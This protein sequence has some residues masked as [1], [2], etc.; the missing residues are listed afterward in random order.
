MPGG[1]GSLGAGTSGGPPLSFDGPAGGPRYT[2]GDGIGDLVDDPPERDPRERESDP[3]PLPLR[4]WCGLPTRE[5]SGRVRPEPRLVSLMVPAG[6][7]VSEPRSSGATAET[8]WPIRPT[9]GGERGELSAGC[10][11]AGAR[12]ERGR[13]GMAIEGGGGGCGASRGGGRT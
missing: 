6:D 5:S 3:L 1:V 7:G 2:G 9:W 13:G 11:R 10:M 4:L 12:D 8:L